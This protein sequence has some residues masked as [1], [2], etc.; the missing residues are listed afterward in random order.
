[1]KNSYYSPFY[2][3]LFFFNKNIVAFY[4]MKCLL[5]DWSNS[6]FSLKILPCTVIFFIL[7]I[8]KV[9]YLL[10]LWNV[11]SIL[12]KRCH[13]CSVAQACLTLCDPMDCSMTGFPILHYILEFAQTH[14]H[15]I[16]DAIQ[17]SHPLSSPSPPALSLSHH[18]GL[19]QRVNSSHQVAKV[20]EL[21]RQH[22]SFTWMFRID[23]L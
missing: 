21:Q 19:F 2:F 22:Q 17:P 7:H 1:M 8:R 23:F 10:W 13:C 3:S 14:V 20:L 4:Q 5:L 12:P 15:W 18:Q 11:L 6:Y 9:Q 16:G